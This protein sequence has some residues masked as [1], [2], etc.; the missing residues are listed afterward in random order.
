MISK[1]MSL[2]RVDG[3]I[4]QILLERGHHRGDRPRSRPQH[5]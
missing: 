1:A 4:Q 3:S 2:L 5:P